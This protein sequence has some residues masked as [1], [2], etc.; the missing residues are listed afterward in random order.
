MLL[1][2]SVLS[3]KYEREVVVVSSSL[4]QATF[5]YITARAAGASIDATARLLQAEAT[6]DAKH[7]LPGG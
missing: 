5:L 2:G 3:Y 7:V 4:A 1:C 6:P